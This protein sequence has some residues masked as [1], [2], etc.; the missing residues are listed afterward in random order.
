[1]T[2]A[3]QLEWALRG[4]V[5]NGRLKAQA[6]P[7]VPDIQLLL[8]SADYPRGPLPREAVAVIMAQPSYWAFCWASGQA[9]ARHLLDNPALVR[10]KRV[11]DF[12][13][14]S[15]VVGI[16]AACAGAASV[17]AC[18][19]DARARLATQLNAALNAV[20]IDVVGALDMDRAD[21]DVVLIADVLY[22]IT[23]LPLLRQFTHAV[24]EI[25]IADSR[26]KSIPLPGIEVVA[27]YETAT[28]PDLD[29]SPEYRHVCIYRWRSAN[30][31]AKLPAPS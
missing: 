5:P 18:D 26:V 21:Y 14:G 4:S 11:L 25:V 12:G 2:T 31:T 3:T 6:V 28:L 30:T 13:S 7:L 19:I 8:L 17:T 15:G 24:P 16:A 22:D 9:L 29:E 23:N 20:A 10:G 27:H 1:M